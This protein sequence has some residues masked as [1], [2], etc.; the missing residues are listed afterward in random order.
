[1]V[2]L[3]SHDGSKYSIDDHIT[4]RV[5]IFTVVVHEHRFREVDDVIEDCSV[6]GFPLI[7]D[8]EYVCFFV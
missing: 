1:M 6:A 5:V 7:S 2:S 3:L 8:C 4:V